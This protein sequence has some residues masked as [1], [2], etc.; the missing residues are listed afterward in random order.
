MI[1]KKIQL[2][3]AGITSSFPGSFP[4]PSQGGGGGGGVQRS[5][6]VLT[7]HFLLGSEFVVTINSLNKIHIFSLGR[8]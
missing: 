4:Y 8:V 1:F 3:V 6:G 5:M 2:L 7:D